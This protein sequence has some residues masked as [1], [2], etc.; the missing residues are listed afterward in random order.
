M[1]EARLARARATLPPDYVYRTPV[2]WAL[3]VEGRI[4][5]YWMQRRSLNRDDVL[6]I[7]SRYLPEMTM[8]A[9]LLETEAKQ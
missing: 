6:G 8:V 3:D 9:L 5:D 2:P 7:L 4:A 1:P